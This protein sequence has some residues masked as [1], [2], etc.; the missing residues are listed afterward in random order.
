MFIEYDKIFNSMIN[1][2]KESNI[3]SQLVKYDFILQFIPYE[4]KLI[5]LNNDIFDF[6]EKYIFEKC[7][8]CKKE[9]KEYFICLICGQKVCT[10]IHCNKSFIHV[11]NCSGDLGPFIY[12]YDMK[13]YLI[14]S[15]NIK[16]SLFPLYINES[17]VGPDH[18]N[19]ARNFKFSKE[20]YEA[21][22]KEYISLDS[23]ISLSL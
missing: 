23:K 13:L 14:N 21:G 15:K 10:D 3:E 1:Q 17:G 18:L 19:K 11:K 6:F 20:K 8:M 7:S 4:F 12:I 16:K 9:V 22:L 5:S 2:M